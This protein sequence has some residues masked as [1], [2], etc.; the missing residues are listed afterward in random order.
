MEHDQLRTPVHVLAKAGSIWW[1]FRD[2][3]YYHA[4]NETDPQR[5]KSLIM[6]LLARKSTG[7]SSAE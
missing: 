4:D 6:R 3:F 1:W 2:N 5:I 7:A